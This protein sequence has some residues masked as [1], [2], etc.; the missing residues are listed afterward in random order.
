MP[1]VNELSVEHFTWLAVHAD[2]FRVYESDEDIAGFVVALG[3]GS[4]YWSGNYAW[5][6]ERFE[7]FLYLD[8]AVVSPQAQRGGVGRA[9]YADLV[10][11]AADRWP[12]IVLEVNRRPPNPVSELFHLAMGY[13][14]IGVREY[15]DGAHAVVMMERF[16]GDLLEANAADSR[17]GLVEIVACLKR[18]LDMVSG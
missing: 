7:R 15:D 5:F 11:F 2:Y 10:L 3:E 14:E 12:R 17:S 18:D 1:H 13:R 6:G 9:L 8:R 16:T 4:A